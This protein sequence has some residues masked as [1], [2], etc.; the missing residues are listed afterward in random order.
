M[1]PAEVPKYDYID[2][3]RGLAVLGVVSVH[4][5]QLVR[6]ASAGLQTLA[7][8]GGSG[9]QLFYLA[10]ALTL[11]LSLDTRKSTERNSTL[12]FF[13]RRY[14]RIAPLFYVSVLAYGFFYGLAPRHWAP[15]GIDWQDIGLTVLFLH[16]WHPE[17]INSVVPGGWSIAVEMTFYLL[18][19]WLFRTLINLRATLAALFVCLFTSYA[20]SELLARVLQGAYSPEHQYLVKAFSSFWIFAQAPVFICGILVFHLSRRFREGNRQTAYLLLILSHGLFLLIAFRLVPA[21]VLL[22]QHVLF[23]FSFIL[24]ALSLHHFPVPLYVN[25]FTI[26]VGKLSFSIYLVHWL[27]LEI[28]RP[29]LAK[30]LYAKGDFSS[31]VCFA[32]VLVPSLGLS[33]ITHRFIETPGIDLGRFIIDRIARTTLPAT[34]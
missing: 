23:A 14:F 11:F 30:Y 6:P 28:L 2:A 9:V 17:T 25:R 8:A 3:L 33:L 13:I 26:L 18:V 12:K 22:P 5:T 10:S 24:L 7:T 21:S 34:R 32:L 29:W 19:P 31:L 4:T 16:G 20:G 15:T 1:T 27:V